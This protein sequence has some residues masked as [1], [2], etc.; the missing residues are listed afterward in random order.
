MGRNVRELEQRF[1]DWMRWCGLR[2]PSDRDAMRACVRS[3]AET[4]R[5][6]LNAREVRAVV[7][8][9][10]KISAAGGAIHDMQAAAQ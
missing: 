10:E 4:Q 3:W 2:A 7:I 8:A 9:V 6:R 5:L 1:I